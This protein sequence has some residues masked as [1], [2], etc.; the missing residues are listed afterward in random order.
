MYANFM[1][2]NYK[3]YYAQNSAG[4]WEE[5]ERLVCLSYDTATSF[6]GRYPQRWYCDFES[7]YI[8]R[9]SRDKAGEQLYKAAMYLR[10]KEN[11]IFAEQFGCV[12][13]G[14]PKC[15]GWEKITDVRGRE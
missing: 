2:R 12:G 1:K 15:K 13:D 7:D 14:C 5:V 6:A 9:L 8:V 11:K 4:E 3:N 10:R